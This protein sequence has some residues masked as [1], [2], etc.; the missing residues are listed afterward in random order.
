MHQRQN[1]FGAIAGKRNN[2]E[3]ADLPG[4]NLT[5]KQLT[6]PAVTVPTRGRAL[7]HISFEVKDLASFCKQLEADGQ[8]FDAPCNPRPGAATSITYITDPFGTYIEL[9]QG[10][11][12]Y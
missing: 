9:T 12:R 11:N 5:F 1:T 8:K 10:L 3:A 7:D 2:F 4:G 6:Q